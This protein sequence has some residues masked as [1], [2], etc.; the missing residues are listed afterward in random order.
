MT[1]SA[2]PVVPPRDWFNNPELS[3][4]T[5]LTVDDDGKVFGHIATWD[6]TH[7]GM[8]GKSVKPPRSQT[9]YAY[10][11]TGVVRTDDGS[12]VR[13]G[14]LTLTGGHASMNLNAREAMSHYDDTASAVVD[15]T[16]G[17][18]RYG[19]WVA[20]ALRPDVTASQVRALRASATSGDW[21]PIKGRLELVAACCVNVPGFPIVRTVVAGG[22]IQALVAAGSRTLVE[23]RDPVRDLEAR[24]AAIEHKEF[25]ARLN[26][27]SATSGT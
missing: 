27:L 24:L 22:Q 20:G 15:V 13:V 23:L 16:I 26:K 10:F 5:P 19:I 3:K 18:D 8:L 7:I 9:D 14:Q 12:D 17:E 25:A 11:K 2:A 21:R 4:V 1:A 6:M